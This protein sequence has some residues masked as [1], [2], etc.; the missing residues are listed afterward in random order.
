MNDKT[1]QDQPVETRPELVGV[2]LLGE[3][4][5]DVRHVLHAAIVCVFCCALLAGLAVHG[6][7]N[8]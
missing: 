6:A 8:A 4:H 2:E 5:D 7:R 1:A 3:L